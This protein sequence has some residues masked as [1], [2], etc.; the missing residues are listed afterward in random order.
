MERLS[1]WMDRM[2]YRNTGIFYTL[3][4]YFSSKIESICRQSLWLIVD[5]CKFGHESGNHGGFIKIVH[6]ELGTIFRT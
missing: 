1:V 2:A 3:D 4:N 6:I 5:W